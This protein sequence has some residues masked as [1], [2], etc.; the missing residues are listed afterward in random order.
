MSLIPAPSFGARFFAPATRFAG[1]D[2]PVR[3]H[4][5]PLDD[6]ATRARIT[7]QL[8]TMARGADS[9]YVDPGSGEGGYRA[10][11]RPDGRD[12]L[13]CHLPAGLR[14]V[15]CPQTED[16][17]VDGPRIKFF[18]ALRQAPFVDFL[19]KAAGQ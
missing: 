9:G 14:V 3:R 17:L 4:R 8:E 19:F 18:K 5:Q 1:H 11:F 13:E 15:H 12:T 10:T 2:E 6:E 16:E 7:A